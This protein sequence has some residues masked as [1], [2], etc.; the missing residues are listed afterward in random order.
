MNFTVA[1][2]VMGD[3]WGEVERVGELGMGMLK[4][5]SFSCA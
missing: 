1:E 5:N 3:K 2:R 4:N